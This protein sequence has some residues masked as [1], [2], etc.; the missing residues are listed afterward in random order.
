MSDQGAS[1]PR[2]GTFEALRDARGSLAAEL[3][4]NDLDLTRVLSE[5]L[6]T[7]NTHFIYELLQNAEDAGATTVEFN[8]CDDQLIVSHDGTRDFSLADVEA[9]TN[10]GKSPKRDDPTQIGKF[11]VGFKA[12]FVYTSAPQ[13]HSGPFSFEIRDLLI[14]STVAPKHEPGRTVFILPFDRGPEMSAEQARGE[15]LGGLRKLRSTS[16]LFLRGIHTVRYEAFDGSHGSLSRWHEVGWPLDERLV[17]VSQQHGD[18]VETAHWLRFSAPTPKRL[19]PG[20]E[21]AVAFRVELLEASDSGKPSQRLNVVPL[22]DGATCV[23]FPAASERSGLKFHVHAPFA[24]TV[25]RETILTDDGNAELVEC[26]GRVIEGVLPELRDLGLINEGLLAALPNKLDVLDPKFQSL[27]STVRRAFNDLPLAPVRGGGSFVPATTLVRS[28]RAFRVGLDREALPALL[29]L[30]WGESE[31]FVDWIREFTGRAGDFLDGLQVAEFGWEELESVLWQVEQELLSGERDLGDESVEVT[32]FWRWLEALSDEQ[33]RSFYQVLGEGLTIDEFSGSFA[34]GIDLPIVRVVSDESRRLVLGG[35][36]YLPATDDHVGSNIVPHALACTGSEEP[37]KQD[38]YLL[39][40]YRACGVRPWDDRA[41]V[42][43]RLLD[44]RAGKKPSEHRYAEDLHLFVRFLRHNP[45]E[46]SL[47]QGVPVLHGQ[48]ASGEKRPC[49]PNELVIDEPYVDSGLAA[50]YPRRFKLLPVYKGRVDGIVEFAVATGAADEFRPEPITPWN[51]PEF[52]NR[53]RWSVRENSNLV[54]RDWDL[55]DLPRLLEGG[56]ARVSWALWQF[57]RR[58][59]SSEFGIGRYSG[60]ASALLHVFKSRLLQRLETEKWVVGRDGDLQLACLMTVSDLPDGWPPPEAGSLAVRAG[61]G[62]RDRA[63]AAAEARRI[64]IAEELGKSAADL[65]FIETLTPEEFEEIKAHVEEKRAAER[66][67]AWDGRGS[68]NPERR[69]ELARQDAEDAPDFQS[70]QRQRAVS[71]RD[72]RSRKTFLRAQYEVN[73]ELQCQ[74]CKEPSQFK[75]GGDWYFEAVTFVANRKKEHAKN[76]LALCPLCAAKFQY[77]ESNTTPEELK[78][79]VQ[80]VEVGKDKVVDLPVILCGEETTIRF[81]GQHFIDVQSALG[82]A[83][84]E[85]RGKD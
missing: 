39:R 82:Q 66:D 43:E 38:E 58:Q 51:N 56:D 33:L 11:G 37:T 73:D 14:P 50:L 6:Y 36:V 9:I 62:A 24:S 27:E 76:C 79:S 78:E 16:L 44:Y 64:E 30:E 75:V 53:W 70:E 49:T 85:R 52:E 22:A 35:G 34:R 67:S 54:A 23:Y 12:V 19:S 46:R 41:I 32:A 61:F 25:S 68:E 7:D 55:R 60:N 2:F 8:V 65:K 74:I 77:A 17:A 40:F 5:G 20:H 57:A 28:P 83:G 18:D 48:S 81:T 69:A 71:A 10:V 29:G 47:F 1:N 84:D 63:D 21:V 72:T 13:V 4:R 3:A 26:L 59:E 31:R 45:G 15:I 42:E 80:R